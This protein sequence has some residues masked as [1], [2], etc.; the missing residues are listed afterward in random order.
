MVAWKP[1]PDQRNAVKARVARDRLRRF[2]ALT[3]LRWTGFLLP[4]DRV[5]LCA[6]ALKLQ[7][8]CSVAAL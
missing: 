6:I 7:R 5:L 8:K 2:A 3:A 4:C 1:L